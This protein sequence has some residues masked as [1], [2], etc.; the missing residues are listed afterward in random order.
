MSATP[1]TMRV[2]SLPSATRFR[3]V[4]TVRSRPFGTISL[5]L[6]A[7]AIL[8][9]TSLCYLWQAGQAT[10]AALKIPSL[11]GAYQSANNLN[12]QLKAEIYNRTSFNVVTQIAKTKYGMTMPSDPSLALPISVRGGTVTRVVAAPIHAH[13]APPASVR[14]PATDAAVTSWW[15]DA[16]VALYRLLR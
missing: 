15:Q 13:T 16:W 11:N 6:A 8:G 14:L 9:L 1:R 12:A 7:T 2:V 4:V 10:D 5:F 3:R